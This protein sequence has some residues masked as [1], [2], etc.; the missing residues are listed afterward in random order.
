M[1]QRL[2]CR[3]KQSPASTGAASAACGFSQYREA[4]A[5]SL[6]AVLAGEKQPHISQNQHFDI[7]KTGKK[8]RSQHSQ[9]SFVI[10]NNAAK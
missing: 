8:T 5:V 10:E 3:S 9:E 6:F 2:L 7:H 1:M 4:L